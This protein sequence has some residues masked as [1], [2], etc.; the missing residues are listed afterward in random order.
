MSRMPGLR[1]LAES[2]T[3]GMKSTEDFQMADCLESQRFVDANRG[4]VGQVDGEVDR[5][6]PGRGSV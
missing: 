3:I 5:L 6:L 1:L 4:S 2:A